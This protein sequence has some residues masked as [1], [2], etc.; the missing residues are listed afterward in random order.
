MSE[1]EWDKVEMAGDENIDNSQ[2]VH[3]FRPP[4]I[5]CSNKNCPYNDNAYSNRNPPAWNGLCLNCIDDEQ[6]S[7]DF[8]DNV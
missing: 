8:A 3:Q 6:K 2:W 4:G 5:K 7:I 1:F